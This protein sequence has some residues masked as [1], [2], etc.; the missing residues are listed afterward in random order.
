MEALKTDYE[1]E[2]ERLRRFVD[3]LKKYSITKEA[4]YEEIFGEEGGESE[5]GRIGKKHW[6]NID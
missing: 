5:S 4:L 6:R 2:I 1:E 3:Q